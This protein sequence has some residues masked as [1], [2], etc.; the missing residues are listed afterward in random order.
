M[1][2]ILLLISL[3]LL[4]SSETIADFGWQEA[5]S[6]NVPRAS[7]AAVAVDG[8]IFVFGGVGG[9]RQMRILA[10]VE[11][12]NPDNG[13]WR[14]L[15][16]M[17]VP[18]HQLSAVEFGSD[19][20]LIGGTTG[21]Q[22]SV[23]HIL[24]YD[25]ENDSFR[26]AGRMRTPYIYGSA[27]VRVEDRILIMGGSTDEDEYEVGGMWLTPDS[28]HW[29][30]APSMNNPR[31]NFRLV[32]HNGNVFAIGGIF[33]TPQAHLE[34]LRGDRWIDR[35]AMTYARG[36]LGAA[37]L[38][39]ALIV[40][41]GNTPRGT[42]NQVEEY[43]LRADRWSQLP[44]MPDAR[45]DFPLVELNGSLYAI[46]GRIADQGRM[47][48]N[49][50]WEFTEIATA[51]E[52]PETVPEY[53]MIVTALPNPANAMVLFSLPSIPGLLTLTDLNGRIIE[54]KSNTSFGNEW[55]W[56]CGRYPAGKYLFSYSPNTG[57]KA[58]TGSITVV[59]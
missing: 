36:F 55:Y 5:P 4:L 42:T 29:E 30:R 18:L 35:G 26:V 40:A 12:F 58:F 45:M 51:V 57:G 14:E 6:M 44:R 24:I 54:I 3:I 27:A 46:G 7:H 59:K 11:V 21:R 52:Y 37:F 43:H 25:T 19:I 56:N 16:S 32:E 47:A 23:S 34:I 2:L 20:F 10:S 48:T 9:E 28:M 53:A 39:S 22:D 15:R 31:A 49:Q 50:V 13:R 8:R 17:P 41:G 33:F 38:D 1:N